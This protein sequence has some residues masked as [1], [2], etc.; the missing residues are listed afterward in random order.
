MDGWPSLTAVGNIVKG[1]ILWG[2][3]GV[4]AAGEGA[5][6][7]RELKKMP[8]KMSRQWTVLGLRKRVQ[9]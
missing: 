1:V 3:V 8:N 6:W 5:E 4:G 7:Q 9:M 2:R